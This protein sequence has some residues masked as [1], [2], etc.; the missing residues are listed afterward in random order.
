MVTSV[1]A[2]H[3]GNF[4]KPLRL[5]LCVSVGL[6]AGLSVSTGGQAPVSQGAAPVPV[7]R[8]ITDL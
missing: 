4:F 3:R 2:S 6:A 8:S 7:I 1:R 5:G